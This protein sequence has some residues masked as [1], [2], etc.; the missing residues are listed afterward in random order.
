MQ[1]NIKFE[2]NALAKNII[3]SAVSFALNMFISFFIT[4]YIT[5]RFGSDIYGYVKLANDFANYAS[6]FSIA[7]NSMAS[8]F[9]MLERTRGNQAAASEYF[10]SIGIANLILAAIFVLPSALCVV[11][12]DTLFEIPA[13]MVFE[14]KLTFALTFLNFILQ[15]IFSVFSNCYYITNTLYIK[16]FRLSQASII[17][18][19]LVLGLFFF[20]TPR[21]SYVVMGTLAA[22]AFTVCVNYYHS[23]RL[24][25]DLKFRFSNFRGKKVLEIL[26]SGIW[27]SIT[28]LSQILT[29][30][31]DLLVTNIF[32]GPVMMGYMSVAKTVPNV[33]ISFNSTIGNVFCPNLMRLYAEGDTD[34][35][36]D[37]AKSAMRFMCLFVSIPSAIIFTMGTDF[38]RLWVP[39]EPVQMINILSI[40]TII[41]SCI[42]GPMQPLYQIFTITN[43]V[44]ENSIV[45][46][47]YGFLSILCVYIALQITNWGV[48]A[49]CGISLFGSLFVALGYHLPYTAKYVGLPK[50]AFVPE[51]LKSILSFIVVVLV[52]FGV[53]FFMDLSSGWIMW[54][55]GAIITAIIGFAINFMIVLGKDEKKQLYDMF[56]RKLGRLLGRGRDS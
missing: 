34:G 48:Y 12:L 42:S 53:N 13:L 24:T 28:Q 5:N 8:R 40:L 44:K 2:K 55:A 15:L 19:V 54:F 1:E 26:S 3:F 52:G 47:V 21:I 29:S 17:N 33:V 27:N 39:G 46:I 45:M 30:G 25:P 41:N 18:V 50:T 31:L 14:V 56:K 51:I 22:T 10:S 16:S 38:Y 11:F 49:V 43:K 9:I 37:A 23:R 7:L 4:P 35:L 32:L 36:K 20:L 6:L